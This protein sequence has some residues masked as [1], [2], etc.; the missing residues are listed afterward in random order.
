MYSR[1]RYRF[2]K[3]CGLV[4][5]F[6]STDFDISWP[7]F[8]RFN[9]WFKAFKLNSH[10]VLWF[11]EK[12]CFQKSYKS[13]Q[14]VNFEVKWLVIHLRKK[15]MAVESRRFLQSFSLP[16]VII[17]KLESSARYS[18]QFHTINVTDWALFDEG[19]IRNFSSVQKQ[20]VFVAVFIFVVMY[21]WRHNI[22]H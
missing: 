17:S 15:M 8:L 13:L 3:A 10:F 22:E 20:F 11:P 16:Q 14:L 1:T 2:V 12:K 6:E 7:S 21:L 5:I 18:G 19:T 4:I 9:F